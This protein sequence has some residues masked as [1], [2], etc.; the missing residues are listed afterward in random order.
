MNAIEAL[1]IRIQQAL[2]PEGYSIKAAEALADIALRG[3][4]RGIEDRGLCIMPRQIS[5]SQK[6]AAM[7]APGQAERFYHAVVDGRPSLERL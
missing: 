2:E 4:L 6:A 3:V 1:K 7:M 5:V